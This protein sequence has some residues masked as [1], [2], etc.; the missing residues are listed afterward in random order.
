MHSLTIEVKGVGE[1]IINHNGDWSGDALIVWA[2][3]KERRE[4]PAAI[5]LEI[6][7]RSAIAVMR[8][9]L[10]SFLEQLEE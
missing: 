7:K 2:D 3:G 1:V 10:I 5:F 6:S 8:D 4:M 9:R